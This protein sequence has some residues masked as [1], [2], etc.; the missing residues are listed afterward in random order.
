MRQQKFKPVQS[1]LSRPSAR[2]ISQKA[3]VHKKTLFL[4]ATL[5]FFWLALAILQ[6]AHAAD[7]G[8]AKVIILK[9]TAF[10]ISADGK[11][12]PL[13]KDM[14]LKQGI[15]V[16]TD[17]GSFTKLLFIDKSSMN[18]GP[19]SEMEITTFPKQEAGVLTLLK[20][21]VRS[22]V[23]KNYMDMKDKDK[24][25]LFI[26]TKTAAMGVRGTDFIVG[27]NPS[28]GA[29]SLDVVSGA[30]AMAKIDAG[31]A[32]SQ[33]AL[34]RA[35]SSPT[36]VMVEKGFKSDVSPQAPKPAP[37][38]KIPDADLNKFK[39]DSSNVSNHG[40][41]E[42][43]SDNKEVA[44]DDKKSEA[45]AETKDHKKLEAKSEPKHEAKKDVAA[46]TK[47]DQAPKASEHPKEA[48][49]TA[50]RAP[51][52]A[53]PPPPPGGLALPPGLKGDVMAGPAQPGH[54]VGRAPGSLP[55][56]PNPVAPPPPP[57][58]PTVCADPCSCYGIC[59]VNTAAASS[60]S[61]NVTVDPN[62]FSSS[63]APAA[64]T[65][66]NPTS[67]VHFNITTQ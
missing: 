62:S 64:T 61:T 22:Q 30:V 4:G 7:E 57:P 16:K 67:T 52:N 37:P 10:A 34:E 23:T 53:P 65:V 2:V 17:K 14:W 11:Q 60:T 63:V 38:A 54:E 32:V 43:K 28:S 19:S 56:P 33:A 48:P 21:Q 15:K 50:D 25:K 5:L 51:G 9:G 12:T 3:G 41:S 8:V 36:A 29:T 39:S 20:G 35:V 26:K 55:P 59:Q 1:I 18:V 45:K 24:S 27:F 47:A 6:I 13:T 42:G 40:A 46:G 49:K 66:I 58:P 44:K 31:M